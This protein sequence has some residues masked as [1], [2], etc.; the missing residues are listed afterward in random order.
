[1]D[2][3]VRNM[4]H[5]MSD[6]ERFDLMRRELETRG[7]YIHFALCVVLNLLLVIIWRSTGKGFPWFAYPLGSWGILI[8]LHLMM[9]TVLYDRRQLSEKTRRSL[10]QRVLWLKERER[11]E[12][13]QRKVKKK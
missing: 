12:E 11:L 4:A 6:K 3:E 2:I 5:E 10:E 8:M 9:I 7:F 1:M 13:E